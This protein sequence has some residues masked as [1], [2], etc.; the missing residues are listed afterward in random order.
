MYAL[1]KRLAG[2][3]QLILENHADPAQPERLVEPMKSSLFDVR[4]EMRD[5]QGS[6]HQCRRT[7]QMISMQSSGRHESHSDGVIGM[8][9]VCR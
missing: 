6:C 1:M 4:R 3:Y 7:M 2:T 9:P 5:H 8:T